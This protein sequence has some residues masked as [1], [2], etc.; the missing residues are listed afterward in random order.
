M[1]VTCI[2]HAYG[3]HAACKP[4]ASCMHPV[5][6][7]MH[8]SSMCVAC[9]Y[10][11][12]WTWTWRVHGVHVARVHHAKSAKSVPPSAG[13]RCAQGRS[14]SVRTTSKFDQIRPGL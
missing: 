9:T 10:T 3:M 7:T 13:R 12:T 14:L 6:C 11:C 1:H 2:W 8:A 4:H 5:T